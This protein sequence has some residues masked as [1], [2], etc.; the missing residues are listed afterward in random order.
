MRTQDAFLRHLLGSLDRAVV[1]T[2]LAVVLS[3]LVWTA[4]WDRG[5]GLPVLDGWSVLGLAML[6]R[7]TDR[8]ALTLLVLCVALGITGASLVGGS[9]FRRWHRRAQ[10]DVARLRGARWEG[11]Q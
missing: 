2:V 4:V 10:L 9:L 1:W 11:E 8:T 6:G 3:A 5:L 7:E